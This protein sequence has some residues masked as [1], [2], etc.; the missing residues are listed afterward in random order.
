MRTHIGSQEAVCHPILGQKKQTDL[1]PL[2]N[3]LH[4]MRREPSAKPC[5]NRHLH[6]SNGPEIREIADKGAELLHSPIGN[7]GPPEGL[8]LLSCA[9]G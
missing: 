8:S 4:A 3:G 7:P 9:L 1:S 2:I 6:R 5:V